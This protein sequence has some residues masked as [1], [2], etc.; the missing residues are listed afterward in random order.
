[1][2]SQMIRKKL[3]WQFHKDTHIK[4]ILKCHFSLFSHMCVPQVRQSAKNLPETKMFGISSH[5]RGALKGLEGCRAAAAPK[6]EIL[7]P[8][9]VHTMI[10]NVLRDFPFCRNQ[11]LKSADD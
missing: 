4:V 10:S 8:D 1:M 11:P 9:F 3:T 6:A 7:K 5:N 2:Q